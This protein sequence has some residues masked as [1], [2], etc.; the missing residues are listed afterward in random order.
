MTVHAQASPT[1]A[2]WSH[3]S[4]RLGWVTLWVT[5]KVP[6]Q[7]PLDCGRIYRLGS[8]PLPGILSFLSLII[9]NLCPN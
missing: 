7:Q 9:N 8:S 1:D 4:A 5:Q 2:K 6:P 3:P